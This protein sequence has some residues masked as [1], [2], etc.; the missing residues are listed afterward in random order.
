MPLLIALFAVGAA[1][2]CIGIHEQKTKFGRQQFAEGEI[3]GYQPA[4]VYAGSPM[5]S[6]M[7]AAAGMVNPVAKVTFA[8]GT[9]KQ[10]RLHT[11]LPKITIDKFPELQPGGKVSLTC[12]GDDPDICYLVGHPLA[13]RVMKTSAFLLLGIVILIVAAGLTVFYIIS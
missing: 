8:D 4:R 9:V 12:F 6:A 13:Q 5:G 2:L 10:I 11:E 7:R 1:L 3:I